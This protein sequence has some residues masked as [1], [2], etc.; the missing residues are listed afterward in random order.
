MDKKFAVGVQ[1]YLK[2]GGP[3]MTM[4]EIVSKKSQSAYL[5]KDVVSKL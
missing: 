3:D 2:S 5:T 4:S 1:V